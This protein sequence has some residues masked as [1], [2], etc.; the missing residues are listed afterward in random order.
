MRNGTNHALLQEHW[1][2][3]IVTFCDLL[4]IER[5][6]GSANGGGSSGTLPRVNV[7]TKKYCMDRERDGPLLQR[8]WPRDQNL[9][10]HLA[11][12]SIHAR[13]VAEASAKLHRQI[14]AVA[15]ARKAN[16]GTS[17]GVKRKAH[18]SGHGSTDSGSTCQQCHRDRVPLYVDRGDGAWYCERCFRAEYGAK[19]RRH[20]CN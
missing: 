15:A 6:G 2:R 12:E 20:T 13:M 11:D 17:M 8:W 14:K 10:A 7:T 16:T 19:W 18:D 5:V 9:Y 3:D 4:G 1:D